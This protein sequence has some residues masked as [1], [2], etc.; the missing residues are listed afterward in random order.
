[1]TARL[2]RLCKPTFRAMQAEAIAV[3]AVAVAYAAAVAAAFAAAFVN[4]TSH[5]HSR[6]LRQGNRSCL[7]AETAFAYFDQQF[8][9]RPNFL[10]STVT[11]VIVASKNKV[12]G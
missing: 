11:G 5:S 8:R 4:R 3:K 7:C 12:F 6:N 1:M 9:R 2:S 10:V